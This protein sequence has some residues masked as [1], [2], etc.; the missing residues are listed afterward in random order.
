MKNITHTLTYISLIF[1][2]IVW[3]VLMF[4]WLYPY[5]TS[6]QVQPYKVLTPIVEQGEFLQYEIDYCKYINDV[7]TVDRQFVDGI[8]YAV[9]FNVSIFT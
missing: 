7:P 8:I 2:V 5:Q 3:A 6:T 4:W 1:I 9:T